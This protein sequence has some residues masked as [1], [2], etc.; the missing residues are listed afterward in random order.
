MTAHFLGRQKSL[1]LVLLSSILLVLSF[2][3]FDYSWFAWIG[4]V[5]LFLSLDGK[6]PLKGFSLAIAGGILFWAG[7][8][9]W[10]FNVPNYS[11]L[12]N[13]IFI[14]YLGLPFGLFGLVFTIIAQRSGITWAHAAAPFIWVSLDFARA[15]FFW[16][17][18]PW[19]MLAH[20]QYRH[21]DIIQIVSW[22]GEYG[23]TFLVVAVNA[24]VAMAVQT[25][26]RRF[27]YSEK[28]RQLSSS[29]PAVL[30]ISFLAAGILAGSVV[31]GKTVLSR[32]VEGEELKISLV[33][34]N[35][36]ADMKWDKKHADFILT[37]YEE[38]TRQAAGDLPDLIAWPETATPGAIGINRKIARRVRSIVSGVN[39]PVLFGSAQRRKFE[40]EGERMVAY[41]NAAFL[42]TPGRGK[43]SRQTYDKVHLL[44]FGEYLPARDLFPWE[45]I[46]VPKITGYKAGNSFTVFRLGSYS[47]SAPICWETIFAHIT[48]KF[49]QNGAQFIINITNAADFGRS[50]APY[51]VLAMNVF[52]AVENRLYVARAAN[53]GIS[54][55]IDPRGRIVDRVQDGNGEDIFVGG[56]LTGRIIPLNSQTFYS[57][58]GDVFA[59]LCSVIAALFFAVGLC[60]KLAR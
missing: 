36:P 56:Y 7:L 49:V 45:A 11:L 32:P 38:L 4:L 55:I 39:V 12:H 13:A 8:V 48:R 43:K 35:I 24:A 28:N 23:V 6:S 10:L 30:L 25:G 37:T 14:P 18:L 47:F 27:A 1:L 20:T 58:H 60:L 3:C 16:L 31:Y 15:H 57:R 59:W 51:Q 29:G 53:T 50:A 5:P 2:P 44:P 41:T 42:L 46:G 9:R 22:T 21:P 40:E 17:A 52:R 34:A 26:C 33:Q 19:G 54:C